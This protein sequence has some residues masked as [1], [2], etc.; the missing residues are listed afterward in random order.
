M[1]EEAEK[2]KQAEED[3]RPKAHEEEQKTKEEKKIPSKPDGQG[4]L[5]IHRKREERGEAIL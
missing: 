2:K 1:L 4:I 5:S 3:E